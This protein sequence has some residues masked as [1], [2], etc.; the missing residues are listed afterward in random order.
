MK[1][2]NQEADQDLLYK[3]KKAKK[4]KNKISEL[5]PHAIGAKFI[6]SGPTTG[7][8]NGSEVILAGTNNYLGLTYNAQCIKAS[9]KAIKK[10]GTGTTGS[11]LANGS[12]KEHLKLEKTLASFLNVPSAMVFTTGYTANLGAISFLAEKN[13]II[14]L[15]AHCHSSIYEGAKLSGAQIYLFKHNDYADLDK[16][17]KR[18][19]PKTKKTLVVAETMYSMLGDFSPLKEICDVVESNGCYLLLDDAH[20]FGIIG[21]KGRGLANELG[22]EDKIDFITGTFSKSLGSIG[23]FLVSHKHDVEA[24]RAQIKTYMFTASNTPG[25]TASTR[26]ALKILESEDQLRHQ[27]WCNCNALHSEL[28]NLGFELGAPA[29]PVISVIMPDAEIASYSWKLLLDEGIYTNLIIPPGAPR[30]LS[31][32]RCSLSAEHTTEQ[33]EKMIFA[34]RKLNLFLKKFRRIE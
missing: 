1:Y 17:L 16:K 12:Y 3:L 29:S 26:K 32:L 13:D 6:P 8:I 14:M 22:V 20:S 31:L 2:A 27:L 33:I 34:Y 7:K 28:V 25:A 30:N 23:G 21:D 10:Y 18:L 4:F 15:D 5:Q 24:L 9:I 19:G 11:R